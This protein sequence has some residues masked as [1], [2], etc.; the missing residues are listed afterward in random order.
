MSDD[1]T[2]TTAAT[3]AGRHTPGPWRWEFVGTVGN[4]VLFGANGF[5]VGTDQ[6]YIAGDRALQAAAPDLLAACREALEALQSCYDVT[7]WPANG[8]TKQDAAIQHLRAALAAA[9]G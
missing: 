8:Q 9:E 7:E 2:T 3:E 4:F 1:E 5:I 6:K